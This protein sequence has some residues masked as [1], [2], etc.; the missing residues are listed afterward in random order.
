MSWFKCSD[1]PKGN[2]KIDLY[3]QCPVIGCDLGTNGSF[4]MVS[5]LAAVSH[6]E[7]VHE[8]ERRRAREAAEKVH[9]RLKTE[10][11]RADK[12]AAQ[13]GVSVSL[14]ILSSGVAL[15][16]SVLLPELLGPLLVAC[17][18]FAVFVAILLA[19]HLRARRLSAFGVWVASERR[20][21]TEL[22]AVHEVLRGGGFRG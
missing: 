14:A 18:G 15:T 19:G 16:A 4:I 10:S 13:S 9:A 6:H 17:L 12:A 8:S 2:I 5:D 20:S 11:F 7:Y 1:S 22:Q 21:S 3:Y